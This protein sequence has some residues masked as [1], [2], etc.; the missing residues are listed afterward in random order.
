MNLKYAIQHLIN[1][2]PDRFSYVKQD[3]KPDLKDIYKV[4]Q[5][6]KKDMAI[7][8]N[9]TTHENE[10]ITDGLVKKLYYS[11]EIADEDDI[12]YALSFLGLEYLRRQCLQQDYLR[13]MRV[14]DKKLKGLTNT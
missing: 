13:G 8:V 6:L 10:L 4:M 3:N 9:S 5:F 12:I 11:N 14:F 7:R 1:L 2:C